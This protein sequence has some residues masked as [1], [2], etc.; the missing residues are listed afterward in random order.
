MI[1]LQITL[2]TGAVVAII[3]KG[4][5]TVAEFNKRLASVGCYTVTLIDNTK[6]DLR[7]ENIVDIKTMK[8]IRYNY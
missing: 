1:V 8:P 6:V 4:I 3:E 7:L 5:N 2:S